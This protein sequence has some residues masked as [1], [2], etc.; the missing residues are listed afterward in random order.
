M[1]RALVMELVEGPTLAERIAQGRLPLDEALRDRAADRRRARGRARAGHRPSRPQAGEHQDA[2][3]RRREGARLRPG[4]GARIGDG[5]G[6]SARR[7]RELADDHEPGVMTGTGMILGTAAYMSPEQAR[8][9]AVDKRADI[10]A[11]GVVLYEMLTGHVRLFEARRRHRICSRPW[12]RA[13]PSGR[14]CRSELP[15]TV[16]EVVAPVPRE[17]CAPALARHR[18]SARLLSR[19]P[20]RAEVD[21]RG[22]QCAIGVTVREPSAL[23]G[24]GDWRLPQ[25][26]GRGR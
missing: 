4:E 23:G 18:R 21:D 17:G 16:R 3:G 20:R 1:T 25:A 11:F 26:C 6:G 8:G 10:W 15:P 24:C 22:S 7:S 9:K 2:S 5:I 19:T 14:R 12:S 13:N